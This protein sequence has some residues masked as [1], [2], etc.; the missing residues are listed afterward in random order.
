MATISLEREGEICL[1]N[2]G[3]ALGNL[4]TRLHFSAVGRSCARLLQNFDGRGVALGVSLRVYNTG[5]QLQYFQK[6]GRD[7]RWH[8]KQ[9]DKG[10]NTVMYVT[11]SIYLF[12]V[13]VD[14][15]N[16]GWEIKNIKILEGK[17]K[18]GK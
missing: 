12:E 7:G 11:S 18:C 4:E 6:G 13:T 3:T 10:W 2:Y 16:L 9:R 15:V 8:G 5:H 17:S 14:T 1:E